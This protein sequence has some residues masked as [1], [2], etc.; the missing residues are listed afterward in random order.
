MVGRRQPS[1]CVSAALRPLWRDT[2]DP[3]AAER[4]RLRPSSGIRAERAAQ[5]QRGL[6]GL[7]NNVGGGAAGRGIQAIA[8][9]S[10]IYST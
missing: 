1:R 6:S 5:Q 2:T 3:I 4:H 7:S 10:T 9:T 8:I